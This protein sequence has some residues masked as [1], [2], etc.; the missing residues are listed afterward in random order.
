MIPAVL[1]KRFGPTGA[2]FAFFGGIGVLVALTLLLSYCTGRS[3]GKREEIVE[4][5]E[6]TIEV[7]EDVADA[8]ETAAGSRVA[9]TTRIALEKEELEDALK[10]TT[11]PDA[12]RVLRGC[13]IMR[14]Q[15]RSTA[16]IPACSRPATPR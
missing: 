10:D 13:I 1:V 16:A 2:K 4:Q 12:R 7:L 9:D 15:G 5:Q 6:R 8:N 11:D 3:D 14:Q